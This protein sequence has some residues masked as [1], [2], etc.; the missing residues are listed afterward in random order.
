[1]EHSAAEQV[2]EKP[3]RVF[4]PRAVKPD[5]VLRIES[6]RGERMQIAIRRY[7]G[8]VMI[9]EGVKSVRQL[10]RGLENLFT[11]SA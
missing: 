7:M 2:F 8:R 11:K 10:C 6:S 4:T 1:M 5:F 9:S 3:R